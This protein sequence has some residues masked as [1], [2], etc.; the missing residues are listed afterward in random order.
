MGF[1]EPDYWI[2]VTRI[3]QGTDVALGAQVPAMLLYPLGNSLS[4]VGPHRTA[5][6]ATHA[7]MHDVQARQIALS[8]HL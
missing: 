7:C 6:A 3:N 4:A 8:E 5:S 1:C 2:G